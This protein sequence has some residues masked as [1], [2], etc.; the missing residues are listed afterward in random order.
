MPG[1]GGGRSARRRD[2]GHQVARRLGSGRLPPD[3][4]HRSP[5]PGDFHHGHRHQRHRDRG[6]QA[7]RVRLPGQAAGLQRG[8]QPGAA[9]VRGPAF[10]P[11]ARRSG[12]GARRGGRGG[13]RHG[14]QLPGHAGRLQGDR[15]RRPAERHRADPR[16][17]R[18]GQGTGRPGHLPAQP[19]GRRPV[20]G[21]QLRGHPRDA[22]GKRAVRPR[23]GLVHRR[24]PPADRQVRAVQ[25]RHAVPRR[26][27]RHAAGCCRAR[28]SACLQEQR[29]ERVGGNETITTDVR[30]IAATNRDLER[31]VADRTS[32]APTSTTG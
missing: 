18:H 32:S 26:D 28:C 7:R 22:A 23:E 14:G 10:E 8:G 24:R 27:R 25:R 21:G 1:H 5:H 3:P 19:P 30:I 13:R 11:G 9:G 17:E 6:H 29:F 20:P 15:P 4:P 12:P 31:M 2:A 16:R